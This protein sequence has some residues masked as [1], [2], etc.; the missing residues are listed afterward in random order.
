MINQQVGSDRDRL[1]KK[2][3]EKKQNSCLTCPSIFGTG[4]DAISRETKSF[5]SPADCAHPGGG[6]GTPHDFGS[7]DVAS[8]SVA[9]RLLGLQ[10]R[11]AKVADGPSS[12][13]VVVVVHRS[14][15]RGDHLV[16]LLLGADLR[17]PPDDVGAG[18]GLGVVALGGR[19]LLGEDDG[20]VRPVIQIVVTLE[21]EEESGQVYRSLEL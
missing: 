1:R 10:V 18:V 11:V 7:R 6:A 21:K 3:C 20:R 14:S 9:P 17:R 5:A 2:R 16:F 15:E 4:D 19:H 12:N 13:V 8:P